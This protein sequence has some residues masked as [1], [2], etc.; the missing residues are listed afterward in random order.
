MHRGSFLSI[1]EVPFRP[2][3]DL[4]ERAGLRVVP[5]AATEDE[6]YPL[7]LVLPPR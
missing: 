5:D 7:V 3:A 4:L 6:R 2:D 1:T